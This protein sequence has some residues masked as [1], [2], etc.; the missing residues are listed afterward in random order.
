MDSAIWGVYF[1]LWGRGHRNTYLRLHLGCPQLFNPCAVKLS[2][3][4][5]AVRPESKLVGSTLLFGLET[6]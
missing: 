4:T 6:K 5:H 3:P 1:G 2:Q